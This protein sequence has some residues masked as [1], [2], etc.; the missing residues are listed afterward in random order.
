[1]ACD[2]A[3]PGADPRALKS[4]PESLASFQDP[5]PTPRNALDSSGAEQ[6]E[7]SSKLPGALRSRRCPEPLEAPRNPSEPDT[8]PSQGAGARPVGL[9]LVV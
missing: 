5:S 7:S 9:P 3:T 1:M 2:S 6:T 4:S 8:L